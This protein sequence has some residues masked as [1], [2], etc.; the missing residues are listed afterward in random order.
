MSIQKR[1]RN[2]N[3]K[4]QARETEIEKMNDRETNDNEQKKRISQNKRKIFEI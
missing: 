3:E 1:L 2:D 4:E